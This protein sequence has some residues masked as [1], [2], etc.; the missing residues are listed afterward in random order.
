MNLT[1]DQVAQLAPDSAS[2]DAARKLAQPR[3]WT[4]LGRDAAALW[5]QCQGSALYQAREDISD[6][7][8]N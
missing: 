3:H 4:S 5:G 6:L 2:V 8:C 7:T 1:A